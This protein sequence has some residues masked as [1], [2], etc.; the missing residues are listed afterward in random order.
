MEVETSNTHQESEPPSATSN[1]DGDE[2]IANINQAM[3][4]NESADE[5]TR[6]LRKKE[7]YKRH[8][9]NQ[10][11]RKKAA[12]E[13]ETNKN[14]APNENLSNHP[15]IQ[16]TP[17]SKVN[18]AK[19]GRESSSSNSGNTQKIKRSTSLE[20]QPRRLINSFQ[21]E[22]L[23]TSRVAF[24]SNPGT[25]GIS[26]FWR[27]EAPAANLNDLRNVING[28]KE[29]FDQ[30]KYEF[31]KDWNEA[32]QEGETQ[33]PQPRKSA[34][35]RLDRIRG[36]RSDPSQNQRPL[37]NNKDKR[38]PTPH[39]L[40]LASLDCLVIRKHYDV[41]I[42]HQEFGELTH[43]L[44]IWLDELPKDSPFPM[45]NRTHLA[46]G[47][48]Y[49]DCADELSVTWIRSNIRRIVANWGHG[50]LLVH[51]TND[52]PRLRK[53]VLNIL[54]NPLCNLEPEHVFMRLER[55]NCGLDA[56]QWHLLK[57][58]DQ[59]DNRRV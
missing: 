52:F 54:W 38:L 4:T 43:F 13:E 5:E 53:V 6:K 37:T 58:E 33:N 35:E 8:C 41:S 32:N 42:T 16:F 49:M 23:E 46:N 25:S 48:I 30:P 14:N 29:T 45:F 56:T 10:R 15:L 9:K 27:S 44:D 40:A 22:S 17:D 21:Y 3:P 28:R 19:R 50:E 11:E 47:R 51:S 18:S 55:A 31:V 1:A 2:S 7:K 57:H 24:G 20:L 26:P 34:M 39:S 36:G 12:K 59:E